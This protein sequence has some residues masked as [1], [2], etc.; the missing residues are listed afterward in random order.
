MQTS[1][2]LGGNYDQRALGC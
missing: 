1:A 2:D